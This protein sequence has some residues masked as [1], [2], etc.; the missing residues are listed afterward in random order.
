MK[1]M[2]LLLMNKMDKLIYGLGGF[3]LGV[4]V[5]A[6]LLFKTQPERLVAGVN[7]ETS[8]TGGVCM[9]GNLN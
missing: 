8:T 6:I 7:L 2:H 1:Y 9:P 5:V 4:L 3:V